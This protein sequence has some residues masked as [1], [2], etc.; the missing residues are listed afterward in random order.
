MYLFERRCLSPCLLLLPAFGSGPLP[1]VRRLVLGLPAVA[2]VMTKCALAKMLG[3]IDNSPVTQK[4]KKK[5][6]NVSLPKKGGGGEGE[7]KQIG[8]LREITQITKRRPT[9]KCISLMHQVCAYYQMPPSAIILY[10]RCFLGGKAIYYT[11]VQRTKP[12]ASNGRP[13]AAKAVTV[14]IWKEARPAQILRLSNFRL[15]FRLMQ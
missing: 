11:Y 8:H 14:T 1:T 6:R 3:W 2:N 10:C 9:R 4:K 5:S 13:F 12:Q 15:S 7:W